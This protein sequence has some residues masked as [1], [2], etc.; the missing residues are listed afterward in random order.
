VAEPQKENGLVAKIC[1]LWIIGGV[2]VLAACGGS[3]EKTPDQTQQPTSGG[4]GGQEVGKEE[5]GLTEEGL[6]TAIEDTETAIAT[7]MAG[8]GFE[9]I[10]VDPVT[11][12]NG[13]ASLG[14][15]P[16]LSDEEFVSQYGYGYTTLPPKQKFDFGE[17]NA[18][19]FNDLPAADQVAFERALLGENTQATFVYMLENEDFEGA[20]GCTKAAIEEVFT[21]EQRNPN[22]TNPFD[23][24]VAQD[25]RVIDATEKWA[26]CMREDG[27]DFESPQDAEDQIIDGL[28]ALTKGQDPTTLTGSDAEALKG[29]QTEER[30]IAAVDLQCQEEHLK[31]VEDQVE[32]D[33]SGRN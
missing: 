20:G 33:I 3:D 31:P 14:S 26:A 6:V 29:L 9:Y 1:T 19:I 28:D 27:Y 4:N 2:L 32:R 8:E 12:R 5:F 22:F 30:A 15:V 7:C 13:M 10:P 25:P 17:E 16:G 11:F 18:A 24:Q 21:A 23:V